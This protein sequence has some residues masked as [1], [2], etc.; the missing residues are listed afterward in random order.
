MLCVCLGINHT[1]VYLGYHTT[2]QVVIGVG[3]GAA[4]GTGWYWLMERVLRPWF[5]WVCSTRV[6][7]MLRLRDAGHHEDVDRVRYEAEIAGV[8]DGAKRE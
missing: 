4:G 3:V 8:A 5:P 1:R 6:A 2:N 7:R